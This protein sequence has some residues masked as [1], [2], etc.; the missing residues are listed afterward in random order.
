MGVTVSLYQCHMLIRNLFPRFS[1]KSY[2]CLIAETNVENTREIS[3]SH[4][5]ERISFVSVELAS[6]ALT[7]LFSNRSI[8]TFP[9][10]DGLVSKRRVFHRP[11]S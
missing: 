5:M 9:P 6:R 10:R 11:K 2:P 8:A 1:E 7:K 3:L 4:H